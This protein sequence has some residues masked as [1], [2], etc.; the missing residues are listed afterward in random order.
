MR[1]R[2]PEPRMG[3]Y[4]HGHHEAPF[5]RPNPCL[6]V[7]ERAGVERCRGDRDARA[8]FLFSK[9]APGPQCRR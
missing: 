9:F 3:N 8:G 4:K 7:T 5:H 2:P 1:P 6:I